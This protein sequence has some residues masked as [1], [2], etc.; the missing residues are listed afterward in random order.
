VRKLSPAHGYVIPRGGISADAQQGFTVGFMTLHRPD[1]AT[2]A[3]K[4]LAHWVKR[5]EGWRVVAYKAHSGG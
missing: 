4:Y 2:L 5:P 1:A 3:L